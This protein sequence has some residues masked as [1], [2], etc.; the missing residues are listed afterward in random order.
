MYIQ[1]FPIRDYIK[2]YSA[3]QH[4]KS[5]KVPISS[6][7]VLSS[8]SLRVRCQKILFISTNLL[9]LLHLWPD[10]TCLSLSFSFVQYYMYIY[11]YILFIHIVFLYLTNMKQPHLLCA[12]K[13]FNMPFSRKKIHTF[14]MVAENLTLI[15][16]KFKLLR[17]ISNCFRLEINFLVEM[18]TPCR[19]VFSRNIFSSSMTF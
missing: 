2:R 12:F 8:K 6:Y 7:Q 18:L 1:F 4:K 13:K 19:S 15:N 17:R 14:F 10:F 3:Y 16:I 11:R 5:N 9:S